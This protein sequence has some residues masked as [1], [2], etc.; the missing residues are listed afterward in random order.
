MFDDLRRNFVMN[1]QSGLKIRPFKNAATAQATDRELLKLS[2]YLS[3][4]KDIDDF[5]SLDHR[6]WEKVTHAPAW[7]NFQ[8]VLL[9]PKITKTLAR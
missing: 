8:N 4:L 9:V 6:N 3:V 1:P 7:D 5:R 2:K